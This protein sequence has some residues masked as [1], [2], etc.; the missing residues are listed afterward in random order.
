MSDKRVIEITTGMS[1][2]D[3]AEM[4]EK[5]AAELE[6]DKAAEPKWQTTVMTVKTEDMGDYLKHTLGERKV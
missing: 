6:A 4:F 3:F 2:E 1:V 5:V